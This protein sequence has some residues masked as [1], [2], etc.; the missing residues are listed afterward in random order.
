MVMR[1][2]MIENIIMAF[3]CGVLVVLIYVWLVI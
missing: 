3:G 1:T 2:R